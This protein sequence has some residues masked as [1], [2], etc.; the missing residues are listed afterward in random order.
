[1]KWEVKVV[2]WWQSIFTE[3]VYAMTTDARNSNSRILRRYRVILS[4]VKHLVIMMTM[5]ILNPIILT[6]YVIQ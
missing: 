6:V 2:R 4:W 5:M 1:M 3:E